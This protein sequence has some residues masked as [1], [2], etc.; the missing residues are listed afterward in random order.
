MNAVPESRALLAKAPHL[1]AYLDR[2]MARASV[3]ETKPEFLV[4]EMMRR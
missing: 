3:Q 1:A 4:H 2:Q